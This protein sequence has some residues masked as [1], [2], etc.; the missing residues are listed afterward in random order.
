[1]SGGKETILIFHGKNTRMGAYEDLLLF[2]ENGDPI[3]IDEYKEYSRTGRHWTIKLPCSLFD[4]A[5]YIIKIYITNSGKHRCEVIK[6]PRMATPK[7]TQKIKHYIEHETPHK[8]IT[9][10]CPL[11]TQLT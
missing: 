6:K 2:N 11:Y 1:M 10:T 3:D 7:A 5:T 8:N 9:P 4:M